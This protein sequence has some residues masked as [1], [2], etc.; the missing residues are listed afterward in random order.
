MDFG[1]AG[2][3]CYPTLWD[4]MK[5]VFVE[6]SGFSSRLARF[7]D[8]RGLAEFQWF[9]M[10]NPDL[11]EVM[12]GCGGLRKIRWKDP[13]RQTGKRGGMR[14]I[15]LHLAELDQVFLVDVYGKDDKEDL[16]ENE[17][18]VLKK[19]ALLFRSESLRKKGSG[20]GQQ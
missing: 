19:L 12:P 4:K 14:I 16:S 3:S 8:D 5:K 13:R 17:K 11:G 20:H 9:L 15:Y 18:K 10:K 1:V 2:G 7:L 6:S